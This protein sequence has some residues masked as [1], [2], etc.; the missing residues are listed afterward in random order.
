VNVNFRVA[1][2]MFFDRKVAKSLDAATRKVLS[3]FGAF[4]RTRAKSSLKQAAQMTLGEMTPDERAA[5]ETRVNLAKRRGEKKPRRP[6]RISKPGDPPKLHKKPSPL[7]GILF[8]YDP[9]EKAVLIGPPATSETR[10]KATEA[11]EHGGRSFNKRAGR[12]Q[13]VAA[14]PFMA[15]AAQ[16]ELPNLARWRGTMK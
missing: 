15:P 10:G 14:R 5:Y 7:K 3:K 4:V 8:I 13:K 11:L 9:A 2:S 12:R 6:E 16:K 1:Q